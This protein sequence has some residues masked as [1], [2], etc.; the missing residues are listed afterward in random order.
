MSQLSSQATPRELLR[1]DAA[2]F[3]AFVRSPEVVGLFGVAVAPVFDVVAGAPSLVTAVAV[4]G[5]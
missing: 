4:L 5:A 3:R 2:G 1:A